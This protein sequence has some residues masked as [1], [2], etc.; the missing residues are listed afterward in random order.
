MRVWSIGEVLWDVFPDQE[1][2]GG[3]PLNVC[4]NLHRM[5]DSATLLSAVGNDER[6]RLALASMAALGLDSRYVRVVEHLPTGVALVRIAADGEPSYQIPRPAAF[7]ALETG[8]EALASALREAVET[9]VDWLYFGSLLQ[10]SQEIEQFT[11]QLA[12]LLPQTRCFYDI[13]LRTGQW[14]LPLVERLSSMATV[15]KL[16]EDEAETLFRLRWPLETD[17]SLAA[18][19]G[20]WATLYDLETICVTLGKD[21]CAIYQAGD[22]HRCDGYPVVVQDT[23]GAGDAF[24]AGFLHGYHEGWPLAQCGRFANA[25]GAIVASRSGATP[26]WSMAECE[27]LMQRGGPAS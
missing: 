19:C 16:N 13:N 20:R 22:V 6:G 1:R 7:D 14:S 8:P 23:V 15:M 3:A 11:R 21:G 27:A 9:R 17:Y 25:V 24:A 2:L 4:A 26:P 5:G 18:F 10:T 12:R